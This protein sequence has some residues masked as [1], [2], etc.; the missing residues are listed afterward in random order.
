[1]DLPAG[2]GP[3]P[4]RENQP[5][6]LRGQ[7]SGLHPVVGLA[8]LLAGPERN[9]LCHMGHIGGQGQRYRT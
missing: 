4:Q 7:F 3:S 8:L 5:G 9:G 2:F 6:L 1:M